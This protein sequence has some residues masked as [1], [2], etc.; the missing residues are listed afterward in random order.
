MIIFADDAMAVGVQWREDSVKCK[1]LTMSLAGGLVDGTI[2]TR[3]WVDMEDM[4]GGLPQTKVDDLR[5]RPESWTPRRR[6][7]TVQEVL[8]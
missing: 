2:N 1:T 7:E 6:E 4:T 8:S 5:N 3:A